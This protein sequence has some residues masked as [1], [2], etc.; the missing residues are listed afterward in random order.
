T[1]TLTSPAATGGRAHAAASANITSRPQRI[2]R[3][4]GWSNQLSIERTCNE[5]F[6]SQS[7]GEMR[8]LSLPQSCSCSS[9]RLRGHG[10][11]DDDDGG[12]G[13]HPTVTPPPGNPVRP[14]APD[15]NLR[16]MLLEVDPHR[17]ENTIQTLVNFGTRATESSQT[18]PN[19]GW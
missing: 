19:R 14:Q 17:I 18:D 10:D 16:Q 9:H 5:G 13:I 6:K 3:N 11:S 8:P 4:D 12:G 1:M 2:R 15:R 7:V